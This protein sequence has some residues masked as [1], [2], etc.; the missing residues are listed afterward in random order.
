MTKKKD[1]FKVKVGVIGVGALGTHHVRLY[2]ECK[3]CSV[4]GIYDVS[5]DAAKKVSEEFNVPVFDTIAD[6][7]DK[8]DALSVA[9]PATKHHE[10]AVGVLKKKKHVLIEKPLAVTIKEGEELVELAERNSVVLAVGHTERFNPATK[11]VKGQALKTRFIEAHR[12]ASYPPAR[13]GTHRR[14]VE[15]GVVLDLMIHDLDLVLCMVES[16]VERIDPVGI[17]VLSSTED[18]ANV[19]IKFKNGCV[20]NV[21]ASRVSDN[22]T[23][24]FRIFQTDAYLTLDFAKRSGIIYKK[25]PLGIVNKPIPVNDSNALYEELEDFV[26]SVHGTITT[27]KIKEPEVSGQSGLRALKL[28]VRVTEELNEYNKKYGVYQQYKIPKGDENA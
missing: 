5:K 23:R 8:C 27:G 21:T 22:P 16:E 9:V 19:R 20:A 1:N 28:A 26:E 11:Y 18:I 4:V 24:R 10:V 25:G 15:V 17:P 6:L 12:L 3:K 14:G 7:T 2:K 13:K